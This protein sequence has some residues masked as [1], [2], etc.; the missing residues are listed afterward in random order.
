M[1]AATAWIFVS[2]LSGM[3]GLAL[4]PVRP[5]ILDAHQGRNTSP[6]I[7][8]PDGHGPMGPPPM[9]ENGRDRLL[10]GA[11]PQENPRQVDLDSVPP[12]P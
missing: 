8:D 11:L 4:R 5:E 9:G 12:S 6:A 10:E 2:P 1:A 3:A 7:P